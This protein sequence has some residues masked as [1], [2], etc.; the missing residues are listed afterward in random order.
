LPDYGDRRA[1]R[2]SK[3]DLTLRTK[4]TAVCLH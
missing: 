4:S 3:V 1:L 2:A